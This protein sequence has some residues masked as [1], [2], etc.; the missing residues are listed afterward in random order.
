[1]VQQLVPN[2]ILE[3]MALGHYGGTFRAVSIFVDVSSFT[4]MATA[5]MEYST[6]GAEVIADLLDAIF[7]PLTDIIYEHGGFVATFA[8]DA[9]TALFPITDS[10]EPQRSAVYHHAVTAAW[11]CNQFVKNN[12][13]Q[14]TRFGQFTFA[15]RLSVADGLV[16]WG[17]WQS[18]GN[19]DEANWLQHATYYFIGEALDRCF[20]A[21]KRVPPGEIVL[22]DAI[23]HELPH[24]SVTTKQLDDYQHLLAII[25]QAVPPIVEADRAASTVGRE[26]LSRFFPPELVER[27]TGGEFRQIVAVFINLA[28]CPTGPESIAFQHLLFQRLAQYGGYLCSVG[29]IGRDDSACTLIL[30]W[31]APTSHENDVMRA[32]R[33]VLE[34]KRFSPTP[35]RTGITFHLG[36]A[37]FIGSKQRA[38]YTCYSVHVALAARQMISADWNEILLDEQ[39]AAHTY[40]QFHL[41]LHSHQKFKGFLTELP[42]YLLERRRDRL[43]ETTAHIPLLGRARELAAL[44]AATEPILEGRFGGLMI[45]TGEAG[46]GKSRLLHEFQHLVNVGSATSTSNLGIVDNHVEMDELIGGIH[47]SPIANAAETVVGRAEGVV[48]RAEEKVVT[49]L[50]CRTGDILRQSLNPFRYLFHQYFEQSSTG[51]WW[52]NQARFNKKFDELVAAIHDPELQQ[53]LAQR[54]SRLATFVGLPATEADDEPDDAALRLENLL[55][56]IK[57]VLVAESTRQPVILQLEDAHQLDSDSI[58]FLELL[59]RNIDQYPLLLLLTMRSSHGPSVAINEDPFALVTDAAPR[60]VLALQPLS[61]YNLRLLAIYH[62]KMA[63][64]PPLLN[65]LHDRAKGNPFFAEQMLLFWQE[66]DLLLWGDQGLTLKSSEETPFA[67]RLSSISPDLGSRL[68]ARLDRLPF[69]VKTVIQIAAV[70]GHE[71]H[72]VV[73]QYILRQEDLPFSTIAHAEA[74]GIWHEVSQESYRFHHALLCDTAYG[75]QSRVQLQ[76]LHRLA[77][78]AVEEIYQSDLSPYYAMLVYHYEKVGRAEPQRRYAK[79]AATHA[80]EL[81]LNEEALHYF[82]HAI[83]LTADDDLLERYALSVECEKLHNWLGHRT[84]QQAEIELQMHI[85]KTVD[86]SEWQIETLL[87][88]ADYQRILGNYERALSDCFDAEKLAVQQ[89][90]ALFKAQADYTIGRIMRHRGEHITAHAY[91]SQAVE[92]AQDSDAPLLEAN[93]LHEI[94]HLYYVQSAYDKAIAHYN[95]ANQ[96]YKVANNQ[97]GQVNCLLMFGVI[98][99]SKGLL[100]DAEDAHQRALVITQTLGWRPGE[101]SCYTYLG[102]VYFDIG[103]YATAKAYHMQAHRLYQEIGDL[104]GEAISLDTL[105]LVSH[106]EGGQVSA[107]TY[108]HRALTIQQA[109]GD[110]HGEAYTQTHLGHILLAEGKCLEAKICFE[111]AL[112]LRQ[113]LGENG[114]AIDSMAGLLLTHWQEGNIALAYTMAEAIMQWLAAHGTDGVEFPVQIY[115]ICHQFFSHMAEEQPEY[116]Q[117]ASQ[118]LQTG[119]Q[120][121]SDRATQINDPNLQHTF[122]EEIPDNAAVIAL[123]IQQ[124]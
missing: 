117:I 116:Q 71:F 114:T 96:I 76:R 51:E 19:E 14:N 123:W 54:R 52:D 60:E 83:R 119:Y 104:E 61:K 8:G 3:Q 29:R 23:L 7:T 77:A 46:V 118:T 110:Q 111:R 59:V 62:L 47:L 5:L 37:G 102:N 86:N 100:S 88:N 69:E 124:S 99:Y 95:Q 80:G 85:A 78:A 108:Y 82:N 81:F 73:L 90:H 84:E 35:I 92:E 22:T 57:I 12:E 11:Q 74:A 20:A 40:A 34:L 27:T 36:Y 70:L 97:K 25:Q 2:F 101:A 32:L 64:T 31:G 94:G 44:T 43:N 53:E 63:L 50:F 106:R 68:I 42:V 13:R 115:L 49:W 91:L 45:V 28:E 65:L 67:E 9:F 112:T 38:E 103:D 98:H 30:F 55:T 6:E 15:V 113:K 39:T 105:G 66:Q 109:L 56:A 58:A 16:D 1:M 121:V 41:A 72:K 18:A 10:A 21:D 48:D 26:Y 33:F 17:I 75:M 93:C 120:L 107:K 122:L 79:L 24:Q 87:R 4:P 89:D